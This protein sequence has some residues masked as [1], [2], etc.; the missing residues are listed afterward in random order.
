MLE[1]TNVACVRGDRP[2]FSGLSF[3]LEPGDLLHVIGPNGRGKTTLLRT[4]CGLTRPAEGEIRWDGTPIRTAG[5]SYLSELLFV[6]H[7]NGIQYEL[8]PVENLQALACFSGTADRDRCIDAL[9]RMG[10]AAYRDFPAKILS[11]GQKRRLA[12]ARLLVLRRK[13]WVLD[14]PLS[15]LDVAT[16]E[17]MTELF[18]E[19]LEADGM[20]LLTSHQE[21]AGEIAGV[22]QISLDL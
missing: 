6:G 22:V 2:L 9:T 8:T 19:H 1:A 15:A 14:E 7:L 11:Q 4:V 20:I 10:L 5:E 18:A 3:T 21:L 13:L 16:T 12:L 17:M